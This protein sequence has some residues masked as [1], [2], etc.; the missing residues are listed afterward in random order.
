M[1]TTSV[2][3]TEEYLVPSPPPPSE[4]REAEKEPDSPSV[5]PEPA[6]DSGKRLD[7]FA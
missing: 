6:E 1:E 5:P 7:L 4:S 2:G 3:R